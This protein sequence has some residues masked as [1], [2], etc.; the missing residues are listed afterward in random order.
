MLFRMRTKEDDIVDEAQCLKNT[1]ARIIATEMKAKDLNQTQLAKL[2]G[3]EK[4]YLS[5]IMKGKTNISL[6]TMHKIAQALGF[7]WTLKLSD[8]NDKSRY[9][10]L[11][12]AILSKQKKGAWTKLDDDILSLAA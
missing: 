6:E 8:K 11:W 7:K 5:R 10:N 3:M 4:S 12:T 2:I 1:M 9:N